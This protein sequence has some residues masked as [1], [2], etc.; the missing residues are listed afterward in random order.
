MLKISILSLLSSNTMGLC[1]SDDILIDRQERY[2]AANY[3]NVSNS[4]NYTRK[5]VNG[6]L[7]EQYHGR[8]TDNYIPRRQWDSMNTRV[9]PARTRYDF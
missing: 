7:R 6:K 4:H 8:N 3:G 2:V 9:A 1:F 5:Q